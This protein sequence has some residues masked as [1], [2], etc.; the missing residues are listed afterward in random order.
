MSKQ[1]RSLISYFIFHSSHLQRN[2]LRFT[3]VELLI[4][5]AIIAILAGMLLPA[6]NKARDKAKQISCT[7]NQKQIGVAVQMYRHD[8]HEFYPVHLAANSYSAQSPTSVPLHFKRWYLLIG[9]YLSG[10]VPDTKEKQQA[11][12]KSLLCPAEVN[13]VNVVCG[14]VTTEPWV[15]CDYGIN[16]YNFDGYAYSAW[17]GSDRYGVPYLKST[18]LKPSVMMFATDLR[19]NS[20]YITANMLT[21]THAHYQ[22]NSPSIL[23]HNR[24]TNVLY[25]DGHVGSMKEKAVPLIIGISNHSAN[26]IPGNLFWF[27]VEHD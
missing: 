23:R 3:L 11:N 4:V 27:G 21:P 19:S 8:N 10:K 2:P 24:S 9:Q 13:P 17:S 16:W 18:R 22:K 15:V 20:Y 26:V 12:Q 5:V 14:A 25:G 7:G 1:R 6:L